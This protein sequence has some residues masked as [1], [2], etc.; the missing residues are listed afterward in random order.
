MSVIFRQLSFCAAA[1][2]C[3]TVAYA[4]DSPMI[5]W[6]NQGKPT[7]LPVAPMAATPMTPPLAIVISQPAPSL[8]FAGRDTSTG[9]RFAITPTASQADD[10]G[11]QSF[12]S[13][14]VLPSTWSVMVEMDRPATAPSLTAIG[15]IHCRD[16]YFSA[17]GYTA[18]N[19]QFA[20]AGERLR[21]GGSF[22]P[23]PG[24]ALDLGYF[25]QSLASSGTLTPLERGNQ[26][27]NALSSIPLSPLEDYTTGGSGVDIGL[28]LNTGDMAIGRFQVDLALAEYLDHENWHETTAFD[29]NPPWLTG[30][31]LQRQTR[32]HLGWAKGSFSGGVEGV[33]QTY[34]ANSLDTRL[35]EWSSFNLYFS[36][37]T[38]WNGNFSIGAT[39][40][41]DSSLEDNNRAVDSRQPLDGI[42]GRVP[43]VRYKQDL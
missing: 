10:F 23:S 38:P 43:Y 20:N 15:Q 27:A 3:A 4:D 24:V 35:N 6:M 19:C 33:Y 18:S 13:S 31:D 40:V 28:H 9:I 1:I 14:S 7:A 2:F 5:D 41:L 39:N 32:I 29:F 25:S 16:G 11:A 12:L 17:N 21:L 34:E 42:F 36:W 8:V 26:N 30:N 22:S 37:Q